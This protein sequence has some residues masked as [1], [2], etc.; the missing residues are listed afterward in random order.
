LKWVIKDMRIEIAMNLRFKSLF[1][2]K[3]GY[4]LCKA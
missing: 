2:P 1:N 4:R 3:G